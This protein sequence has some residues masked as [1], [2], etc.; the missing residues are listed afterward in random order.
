[1]RNPRLRKLKHRLSPHKLAL[2]QAKL[3]GS[4]YGGWYQD[5]LKKD[6]Q[7]RYKK[8]QAM[9]RMDSLTR[10]QIEWQD[11][12]LVEMELVEID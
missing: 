1:M 12:E 4:K 9:L 3:G 6:A 8:E 5:I 10:A 2:H 11:R 7:D